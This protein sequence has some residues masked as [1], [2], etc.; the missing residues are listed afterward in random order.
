VIN[1]E[2]LKE[3]QNH[4][5]IVPLKSCEYQLE[6]V[7]SLTNVTLVQTYHNPTDKFLEIEYN[8]PINPQACIYKFSAEFGKT[9]I[10]GIVKEKE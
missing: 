7:N 4:Y 2:L 6:I 1:P 9:R 5:I 8:F 10:E 3:K